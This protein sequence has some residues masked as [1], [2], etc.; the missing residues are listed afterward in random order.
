MAK[1]LRICWYLWL[2]EKIVIFLKHLQEHSDP[3]HQNIRQFIG[4][5]QY[6]ILYIISYVNPFDLCV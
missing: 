2:L 6:K 3:L 1:V 4:R 5:W